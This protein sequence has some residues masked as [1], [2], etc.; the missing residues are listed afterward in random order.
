MGRKCRKVSDIVENFTDV[1]IH[2]LTLSEEDARSVSS[3]LIE[4]IVC[5]CREK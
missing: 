5:N 3:F 2:F 4:I 1:N